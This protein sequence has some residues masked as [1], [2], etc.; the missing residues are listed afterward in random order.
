MAIYRDGVVVATT[1]TLGAGFAIS[2]LDEQLDSGCADGNQPCHVR[3]IPVIPSLPDQP[4]TPDGENMPIEGRVLNDL[5]ASGARANVNA[6][7]FSVSSSDW[8]LQSS[9][10]KFSYDLY[11]ADKLRLVGVNLTVLAPPKTPDE[12]SP[13]QAATS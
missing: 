12:S 7:T 13:P 5:A 9:P 2:G 4:H 1:L 10:E 6:R 8:V 3:Y 11:M